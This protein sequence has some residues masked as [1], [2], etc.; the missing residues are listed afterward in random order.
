MLSGRRLQWSTA[1]YDKHTTGFGGDI[2][3][4]SQRNRPSTLSSAD[5]PGSSLIDSP[6]TFCPSLSCS[7]TV[8]LN[9][10]GGSTQNLPDMA[11][12][13]TLPPTYTAAACHIGSRIRNVPTKRQRNRLQHLLQHFDGDRMCCVLHL[14]F[15]LQTRTDR[16]CCRKWRR[17]QLS[18]WYV[19]QFYGSVFYSERHR[20]LV[21]AVLPWIL[22][23]WLRMWPLTTATNQIR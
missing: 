18:T 16:L 22:K 5:V 4:S 12:L 19:A 14:R 1:L 21:R 3:A 2:A 9:A 20:T 17:G 23:I 13:V 10:D 8:R 11:T 7:C 6:S 15:G